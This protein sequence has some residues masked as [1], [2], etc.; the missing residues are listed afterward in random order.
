V[1]YI[2]LSK[3]ISY[4]LRHHPEAYGL[5]P[6]EQGRVR[7]VQLITALKKN[8]RWQ[9]VTEDDLQYIIEHSDKKRFEMADGKIRALYGHST[10]QKID[11]QPQAPP[12]VLYH[13]T[14]R[15]F[16]DAIFEKGLLPGS[17]QYV[18]LSTDTE[19]ALQVG[20]RRDGKPML[21]EIDAG[22]AWADGVQFYRGNDL[23]WLADLIPSR[24]IRI[25]G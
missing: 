19:T 25:K 4:A 16:L 8:I 11:K 18:H 2:R 12:E 22:R 9:D 24:Y 3:E 21:L 23:V 5:K 17:R 13:G 20:Q 15:R 14:A 7:T 6:D 1:D 10:P